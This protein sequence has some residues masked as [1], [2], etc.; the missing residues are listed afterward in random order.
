MPDVTEQEGTE[1]TVTEWTVDSLDHDE[2]PFLSA[3]P[4]TLVFSLPSSA[5]FLVTVTE[6]DCS[7]VTSMPLGSADAKSDFVTPQGQIESLIVGVG[8][9]PVPAVKLQRPVPLRL[10]RLAV[11]SAHVQVQKTNG[12]KVALQQHTLNSFLD[13]LTIGANTGVTP[14]P[15]PC[16]FEPDC[17]DVWS[18]AVHVKPVHTALKPT[19]TDSCN[20][21]PQ[22]DK[23]SINIHPNSTTS[24]DRPASATWFQL[25][26]RLTASPVPPSRD[27]V[28]ISNVIENHRR[29]PENSA[30]VFRRS[31]PVKR[32]ASKPLARKPLPTLVILPSPTHEKTSDL[33]PGP[34]RD[35]HSED[36]SRGD[37]PSATVLS[38]SSLAMSKSRSSHMRRV[39]C[40]IYIFYCVISLSIT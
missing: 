38:P 23:L 3:S 10:D 21:S 28:P 26:D 15:S 4:P 33:S 6:V 32:L 29:Q 37:A 5:P 7:V 40:V 27:K 14:R 31:T 36:V 8:V 35:P 19:Y 39:R 25:D 30:G 20:S 17:P 12:L 22:Q 18:H 16:E 34:S 24:I 1:A 13:S 9:K 11:D 2:Q